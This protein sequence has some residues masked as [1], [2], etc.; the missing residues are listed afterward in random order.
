VLFPDEFT[1]LCN[2][3]PEPNDAPDADGLDDVGRFARFIRATKAPPRD[4]VLAKTDRALR[5]SAVFDRIGCAACHVRPMPTAPAGTK[6]L[7]GTYAIPDALGG[8]TFHPFGDFLMHDV[9]TGDGI[10]VPVPEHYGRAMARAQWMRTSPQNF[11]D[12][13]NRVRTAALW[14][15]RLRT[16]LMHDGESVT[17]SDAI[18][19][20][21]GEAADSSFRFR[22]L[23]PADR[24]ALLEVLR[25]L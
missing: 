3:A 12:N 17:P 14:G 25:S 5:G 22:L 1:K 8:R 13:R 11:H 2:T 6:I 21:R 16:R 4:E 18:K 15:L 9:G 24:E 20:H 10:V 23:S 7:G 19:R